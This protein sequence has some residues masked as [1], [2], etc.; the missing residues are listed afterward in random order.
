MQD[1]AILVIEKIAS[2]TPVY[3]LGGLSTVNYKGILLGAL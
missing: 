3:K 2:L 1:P